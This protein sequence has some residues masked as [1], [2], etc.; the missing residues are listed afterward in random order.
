MAGRTTRTPDVILI[1]ADN[2]VPE[3][4]ETQEACDAALARLL[5]RVRARWPLAAII[6]ESEAQWQ[7]SLAMRAGAW[8][9][10]TKP[11]PE[12][13]YQDSWDAESAAA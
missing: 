8:E 3:D 1:D 12:S 10:V 11:V 4:D 2:F 7:T 6:C 13:W 5:D 9:E